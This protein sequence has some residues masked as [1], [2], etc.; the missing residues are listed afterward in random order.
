MAG[1]P[2]DKSEP[3]PTP[4]GVSLS[5]IFTNSLHFN[6][7]GFSNF[8]GTVNMKGLLMYAL[9]VP[10]A[11]LVVLAFSVGSVLAQGSG[12]VTGTVVDAASGDPL[13]GANIVVGGT[14]IGAATDLDG[15]YT[16]SNAPA[17]TRTLVV[18]YIGYD[19]VEREVEIPAGGTL[20]AD[21]QLDWE[22][23]V[24]EEIIIT[25]QAQ[26][27]V[28][29]INQQL[30]SRTITN[31][32]SADRIQEL[33]DVNAAE[34]VGRLPG[35]AIQRSG[36]E[37]NKVSIRGLSPKYNTVTVN[38]VRVPSTGGTDRSVDLSLISSNMLSG[39]EV[40]KAITPDM[41]ADAIGGSVDLKLR[42]A[43]E[44]LTV[45][46]L[47]QG[48]YN[49]LQD[50]TGNYK[51]A[52]SV[53]NR[54]FNNRLGLIASFNIDDYN[55]SADKFSGDYRQ[56]SDPLTKESI[57]IVSNVGLRD[58][59]VQRGRTGASVVAD[60]RIP[61]GKIT[62]NSFFNRLTND[63][64]YRVH[65]LNVNDQRH[66]YSFEDRENETSI[67]TGAIG[68]EQDFNLF[69]YDVGLARTASRSNSPSDYVW[70]FMQE[71]GAFSG[72]PTPG[73]H[74]REV[75]NL[76][77]VDTSRT[78]LNNVYVYQTDRDENVT[79]AQLNIEVPFRLGNQISGLVK[80]GGKLRWLDRMNDQQQEGAG[81][82]YYGSGA[83]YLNRQLECVAETYPDWNLEEVVGFEGLL[84]I[85]FTLSDYRRPD[86]LNGEYDL[87]LVA[88]EKK[89]RMV[90]EALQ[91]C[92][93]EW[94]N[95]AIGSRGS[96]YEG[97]ERYQAGYIMAEF[98]LGRRIT[99]IPGIRFEK[100]YSRYIGQRYREVVRNNVQES[101]AE[102]DTLTNT[103]RNQFW[104]P[105]VHLNIDVTDWLKLRFARTETLTRPDYIHYA[106]ITHINSYQT[107]VRAA[108]ALL[109]PSHSTNYDAALSIYQNKV[110]LFSVAAFQKSID[111][112]ILQVSYN[113]HPDVPLLPGMNVP[114]TWINQRPTADTY[115][116]NPFKAKYRG[117]EF[118]WQTNFWYLPS[119]LKGIVLNVNY[120]HIFSE[121]TYQAYYLVNS[122]ELIRERPPVYRK[123]V[124]TDSV[125]TARMPDQPSHIANVTLGYDYKGFSA[126]L[127]FLYQTN[128]STYINPTNPIRDN[129]SG[130]YYRWDLSASQDIRGGIE[131]FANLNN[132][133]NRPDRNFRASAYDNPTYTEYYGLTVDLGIRYRY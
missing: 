114:E 2:P 50:Y 90:T 94:R 124:K 98:N 66:Y 77:T 67:F 128:T 9:R 130:D 97:K 63:G 56:D 106:P 44:R 89:L 70:E 79:T 74:P 46:F 19:R 49:Q 17:G 43:P 131:I 29:A 121:T 32:V 21:F 110:G 14:S 95:M 87:G 73:M 35:V 37:A 33:P 118:D 104:L 53:S 42:E 36:G 60:Y 91:N 5:N 88:D 80:T 58:E 69:R 15:R 112:L 82:M 30:S 109:K 3:R 132:L 55:R 13:P 72:A 117:I 113:L 84:P 62:A 129:Y 26:G 92:P 103:R 28:S 54:F 40:M 11:L 48:G 27:Q 51:F 57:I 96:D 7:A 122:K 16:I 24:G 23:V 31:I 68:L 34:S 127:S 18:T 59:S 41:D 20:T 76:S 38:G 100:D 22:G 10:A 107:Y 101:P 111:D 119:F 6:Y 25:A 64:L 108:N 93:S 12:R 61:L 75:P 99:L 116:N 4:T 45:D 133:N 86:L 123:E 39:I 47:A 102:L 65:N 78:G 85:D 71:G 81:G 126:R 52:G 120:T 8:S 1:V 105:M 115:I 83:G 125:R